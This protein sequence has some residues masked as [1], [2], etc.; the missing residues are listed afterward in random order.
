MFL[1]ETA[2]GAIAV[3]PRPSVFRIRV[4]ALDFLDSLDFVALGSPQR[5]ETQK[6]KLSMN[7]GLL[8]T[9]AP[10]FASTRSLDHFETLAVA[11]FAEPLAFLR[12][13]RDQREGHFSGL[14]A[15]VNSLF[16]SFL[17]VPFGIAFA[18]QLS[19]QPLI[20][21][22]QPPLFGGAGYIFIRIFWS[23]LSR[24]FFARSASNHLLMR[25]SAG[26]EVFT[27]DFSPA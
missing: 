17:P 25:V 13:R 9:V 21:L 12:V 5:P 4:D 20:A 23:T 1:A 27:P 18:F 24:D 6:T 10:A 2:L 15:F 14:A 22:S 7:L 11:V 8:R 16:R 19:L 3:S 26:L